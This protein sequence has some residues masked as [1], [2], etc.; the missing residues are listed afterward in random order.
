MT[1]VWFALGLL[2][3]VFLGAVLGV[4]WMRGKLAQ[5]ESA[6]VVAETRLASAEAAASK[7]QETF[8]ALADTALR[9]NQTAFLETARTTLDT[10]RA[11]IGGDLAKQQTTVE[12]VVRA[13]G[14][15]LGRLDTQA[16]EVESARQ[17]M[18]GGLEEQLQ[19]LARETVTLSTALRAPQIRGRWGETTLRRVVE[20]AGMVKHCDFTEQETLESD[21]GRQRPDMIVT[22]PGGRSIAVDSKVPLSAFLDAAGARDDTSRREALR[23]HS[24]QVAE[25]VAKLST[26]AYWSQLQPSPEMVI[27]FLPG[28]HFFSAALEFNPT[29][30]EDAIDRKI[31]LATPTTLIAVL[32]G[33]SFD[34]RQHQL[35]ENAEEI[36]R[37]AAELYER[38]LTVQDYYADTGR[39]LE[40]AVQAY[41]KSVGSWES[42]MLPSLRRIR[43]L[44]AATGAEPAA[45]E[46][47]DVATREPKMI[48]PA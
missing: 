9:S 18:F 27:L 42:R 34:W 12:G 48:E 43:E 46:Q 26:K 13:L 21:A 35:A 45:P 4:L 17:K 24:Q 2:V 22:L 37:V 14:E 29:L 3:G 25:H 40:R 20:L 15:S 6:R 36:R 31:L 47:I 5:A 30:I 1:A 16:R 7:I 44:G 32:K 39:H 10:V 28:D 19:K 8:Q 38:V 11:Q 41:N 33:I 23:R